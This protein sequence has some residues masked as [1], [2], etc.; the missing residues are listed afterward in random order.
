MST[1]PPAR[2]VTVDLIGPAADALDAACTTTGHTTTDTVNR[3]LQVYAFVAATYTGG[4]QLLVR[5]PDGTLSRAVL[6]D[7]QGVTG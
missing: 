4:G 1:L 2:R 6:V 5:H 7:V 3:A